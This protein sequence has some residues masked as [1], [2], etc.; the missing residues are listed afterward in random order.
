MGCKACESQ[1]SASVNRGCRGCQLRFVAQGPHFFASICAGRHLTKYVEEIKATFGHNC[2]VDEIH[3][4]IM[5]AAKKYQR[6]SF[7]A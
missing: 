2:D 1:P 4:E 6:G 3:K 5:A 7:N